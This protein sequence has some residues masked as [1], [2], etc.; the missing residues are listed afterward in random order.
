MTSVL[1]APD[2]GLAEQRVRGGVRV[3][4]EF[5]VVGH[6]DVD[7][8]AA[9][10]VPL[11]PVRRPRQELGRR[12]AELLLDEGREGLRREQPVVDPVVVVRESSMVRRDVAADPEGPA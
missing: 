1:S 5:A 10:A 4:G 9:V 12:V 3:P 11:G 6:D 7:F 2:V 8:T